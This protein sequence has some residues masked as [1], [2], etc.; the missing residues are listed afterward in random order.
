MVLGPKGSAGGSSSQGSSGRSSPRRGRRGAASALDRPGCLR[1]PI[2][3]PRPPHVP[4]RQPLV[5]MARADLHVAQDAAAEERHDHDPLRRPHVLVPPR[6][7]AEAA[8][9]AS[10][11]SASAAATPAT[12]TAPS[13]TS[14]AGSDRSGGALLRLHEPR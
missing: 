13:T 7:E 6:Q 12:A 5:C 4:V 2:A 9:A 11:S 14:A 10:A 3:L 8:A 1:A